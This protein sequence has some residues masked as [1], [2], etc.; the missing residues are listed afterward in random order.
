MDFF[1]QIIDFFVILAD[2]VT[3]IF[4]SIWLLVSQIPKWLAWL[5]VMFLYL[6]PFILP[7]AILSLL[8]SVLFLI[9]GRN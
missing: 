2:I 7:F 1:T 9:L 8:L 4:H 6:P 3:N 5:N